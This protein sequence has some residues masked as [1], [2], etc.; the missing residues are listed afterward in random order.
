LFVVVGLDDH[1]H[2]AQVGQRLE[3]RLADLDD[4]ADGDCGGEQEHQHL[5]PDRPFDDSLEHGLIL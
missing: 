3:R 1:L 5:V 2:V 4:P